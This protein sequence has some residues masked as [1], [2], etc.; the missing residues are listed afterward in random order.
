MLENPASAVDVPP[1]VKRTSQRTA[2]IVAGCGGARCCIGAWRHAHYG[3]AV[4]PASCP[5]PGAVAGGELDIFIPAFSGRE[6]PG[7]CCPPGRS[8]ADLGPPAGFTRGATVSGHGRSRRF[9]K[10]VVLVSR[11]HLYRI[12]R[13]RQTE[14]GFRCRRTASDPVRCPQYRAR[15]LGTRGCDPGCAWSESPIRQ[16]PSTGGDLAPLTKPR[17]VRTTSLRNSYP[18]AAIFCTPLSAVVRKAMAS[19]SNRWT[20]CRRYVSFRK[21]RCP[22]FMYP[23]PLP[24][25]AA[26]SSSVGKTP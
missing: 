1:V 26:I 6:I 20:A 5:L 19:T 7:L 3:N 18:M 8:F 17:P 4:R 14:K 15:N 23:Q 16:V 22:P 9:G 12:R 13:T 24:A 2:W 21:R 25:K 10:P 11:Q